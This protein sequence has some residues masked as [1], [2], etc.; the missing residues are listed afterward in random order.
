[1]ARP[2][3]LSIVALLAV[4][5]TC[6]PIE[7]PNGGGGSSGGDGNTP[8]VTPTAT[9]SSA[10]SITSASAVLNGDV[11]P[12]GVSTAA[13]FEYG[14]SPALSTYTTTASQSVGSGTTSTSLSQSITNLTSSTTYY[15]RIAASNSE[16]TSR[17]AIASLVTSA[18]YTTVTGNWALA[19]DTL[20]NSSFRGSLSATLSLTQTTSLAPGYTS[21]VFAI[22][23]TFNQLS[24]LFQRTSNGTAYVICTANCSG[25]ILNGA[26]NTTLAG[27]NLE[28]DLNG[29]NFHL[30][31]VSPDYTTMWG[32]IAV[33]LDMTALFGTGDGTITLTG[34]WNATRH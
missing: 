22:T 21:D 19:V 23:G 12:N 7:S 31:G 32:S 2:A 11:N 8:P 9:T 28:F 4:L 15:F 18:S 24:L 5:S 13:W 1:M 6:R 14:T 27:H 25:N 3:R 20:S 17:G 34:A 33:T 30:L 10:T 26:I 16:A 29:S